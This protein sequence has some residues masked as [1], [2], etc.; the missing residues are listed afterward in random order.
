MVDFT[1]TLARIT[2]S[3][4]LMDGNSCGW[5]NGEEE[6]WREMVRD[7]VHERERERERHSE[8]EGGQRE[9]GTDTFL[10]GVS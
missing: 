2:S 9:R 10:S 3:R 5:R 4:T 1:V 7:D 6:G 8:R